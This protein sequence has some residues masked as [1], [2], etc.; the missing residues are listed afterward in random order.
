MVDVT[1]PPALCVDVTSAFDRFVSGGP[2]VL[3]LTLRVDPPGAILRRLPRPTLAAPVGLGAML[4]VEGRRAVRLPPLIDPEWHSTFGLGAAPRRLLVDM[5]PLVYAA[6]LVQFAAVPFNATVLIRTPFGVAASAPT[7]FTPSP[8]TER[9]AEVLAQVRAELRADEGFGDWMLQRGPSALDHAPAGALGALVVH[10]LVRRLRTARGHVPE[11]KF[12]ELPPAL[13]PERAGLLAERAALRGEPFAALSD[14]ACATAP[15][16]EPW[17][18][19]LTRGFG[20]TGA[21][22]SYARAGAGDR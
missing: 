1:A 17:M 22:H 12:D 14:R 20:L 3:A 6:P 16:L 11:E 13:A 8:P 4:E 10:R 19:E 7:T 18:S 5:A 21:F 9:E 15:G 2:L